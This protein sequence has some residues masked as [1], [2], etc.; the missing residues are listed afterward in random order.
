MAVS[1]EDKIKATQNRIAE[2]KAM[3]PNKKADAQIASNAYY[4]AMANND[5]VGADINRNANIK[6]NGIVQQL[7]SELDLLTKPNGVLANLISEK[8]LEIKAKQK[9]IDTSLTS[10]QKAALKSNQ[11]VIDAELKKGKQKQTIIIVIAV[12]AVV[13]I[14]I[15]IKY[16]R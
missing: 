5:S 11:S 8:Q 1:I 9:I 15:Y 14:F 16:F 7:Q 4:L 2:I 13:S 3:I 10:E 12:I 6:A